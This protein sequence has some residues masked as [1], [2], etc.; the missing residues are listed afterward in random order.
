MTSSTIAT[1]VSRFADTETITLVTTCATKQGPKSV[2]LGGRES[3]VKKRFALRSVTVAVDIVTN[4]L[5]V[6]VFWVGRESHAISV[7]LT[8]VVC[9]VF[10]TSRGN[11]S[12]RAVGAAGTAT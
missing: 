7:F 11:A 10:V 4:L 3:F 6:G 2:F 9:T 12:V 5:S 1:H 8:R